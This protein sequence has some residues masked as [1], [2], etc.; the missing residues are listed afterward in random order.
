MDEWHYRPALDRELPLSKQWS[1]IRRETGFLSTGLR[2][3][4]WGCIKF[5][6]RLWHRLKIE[7]IEH[8]PAKPPF[9]LIANHTS[10]LD[11]MVLASCLRWH[12]RDRIFPIAAGDV[13]FDSTWKSVLSAGVL[14]ALPMWRKRT[15]PKT[16]VE[17]RQR[18]VEEEGVYILFPEGCR[19]RDG[20]MAHFKA[21]LGM[22][23]AELP[24]PV[25]P[26]YLSGCYESLPAGS[27]LPR[28]RAIRVCISERKEYA[29]VPNTREG[30]ERIAGEMEEC[31]SRLAS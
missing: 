28:R 22:F 11:A 20:K 16:L 10:H 5:Y 25:V 29:T 6:L 12:W 14:N 9:I 4:S 13:F 17:L 26:C 18:L 30:W 2:W 3:M 7:G 1:C 27:H 19:S 21:G 8:L 31:V 23:L 24:V 15:S